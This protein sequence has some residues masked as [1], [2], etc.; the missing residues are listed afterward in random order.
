MATP[1][2]VGASASELAELHKA[3]G[4]KDKK[5]I[6]LEEKLETL[7]FKRN[8]DKMKMKDLEK[9][10]MQLEQVGVSLVC[11]DCLRCCLCNLTLSIP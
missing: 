2:P 4:E 5:I 6:D 8:E 9:A 1:K 10:R 7:K 3:T 11:N